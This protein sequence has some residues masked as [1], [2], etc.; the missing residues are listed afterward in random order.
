MKQREPSKRVT[1]LVTRKHRKGY[2]FCVAV[3][4]TESLYSYLYMSTDRERGVHINMK[5]FY[6]CHF[7]CSKNQTQHFFRSQIWTPWCTLDCVCMHYKYRNGSSEHL[8]IKNFNDQ[9]WTIRS[10]AVI[11]II[12]GLF[13]V[14]SFVPPSLDTRKRRID[15]STRILVKRG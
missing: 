3:L 5:K 15:C 1:L 9:P 13:Y 2:E 7:V 8:Q 6:F 11:A 14:F 10:Q 12:V 4:C